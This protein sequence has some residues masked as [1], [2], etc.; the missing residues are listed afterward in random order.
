LSDTVGG[1]HTT[2]RTRVKLAMIAIILAPATYLT[3]WLALSRA[4][5]TGVVSVGA[6]EMIRPVYKP[7]ILYCDSKQPGS[8]M[9]YRLWWAVGADSSAGARDQQPGWFLSPS[10]PRPID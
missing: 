4:V 2:H 3:S 7:L 8:E 6:G 1:P 9:L 5:N 10:L